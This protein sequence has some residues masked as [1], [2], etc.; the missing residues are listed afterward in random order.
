MTDHE[1]R[2]TTAPAGYAHEHFRV[3]PGADITL[4]DAIRD[5][6]VEAYAEHGLTLVAALRRAMANDDEVVAIWSFASWDDW[7]RFEAAQETVGEGAAG[8]RNSSPARR[9]VADWR[10][11]VADMVTAC[12]RILLADAPLSPLR[13]GRQPSVDDRIDA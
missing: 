8:D 3:R 5:G 4:L 13:I 6:A 11:S 10:S 9:A 12:D 7:A 1:S 2:F